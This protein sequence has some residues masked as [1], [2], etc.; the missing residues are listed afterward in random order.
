ME[1]QPHPFHYYKYKELIDEIP[2]IQRT[3]ENFKLINWPNNFEHKFFEV[4]KL[5]SIILKDDQDFLCIK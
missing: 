4:E 1:K 3:D 2:L 5:T